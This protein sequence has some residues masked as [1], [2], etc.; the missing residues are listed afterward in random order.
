M[1]RAHIRLETTADVTRFVNGF[2]GVGGSD[3]FVVE[4]ADNNYRVSARS[5]LGMMYMASEHANSMYLVN[6]T[7]EGSFPHFIDEFRAL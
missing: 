5:L 7:N 4:T 2:T 3:E 6:H 1:I